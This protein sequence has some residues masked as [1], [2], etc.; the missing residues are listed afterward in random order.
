MA[1]NHW[2]LT[3]LYDELPVFLSQVN[4]SKGCDS[5]DVSIFLQLYGAEQWVRRTG[6]YYFLYQTNL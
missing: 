5:R 6:K 4:I 2:K 1:H 3:G